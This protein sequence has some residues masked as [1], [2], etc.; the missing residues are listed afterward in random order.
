MGESTAYNCIF[1]ATH[2]VHSATKKND[3]PDYIISNC[4]YNYECINWAT[5]A[6]I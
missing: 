2:F 4:K 1:S 5:E 3:I 6:C